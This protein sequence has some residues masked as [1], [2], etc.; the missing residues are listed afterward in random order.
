MGKSPHKGALKR[1]LVLPRVE[2]ECP[3]STTMSLKNASLWQMQEG[4][5]LLLIILY[6]SIKDCQ[7]TEIHL[8]LFVVPQKNSKR[9]DGNFFLVV[10]EVGNST[11]ELECVLFVGKVQFLVPRCIPQNISKLLSCQKRKCS[12]KKY[13]DTCFNLYF[14]ISN[15]IH[16]YCTLL[17]PTFPKRCHLFNITLASNKL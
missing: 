13:Q 14:K 4:G 5:K 12:K 8:I 3:S 9:L 2:T 16:E 7:K 11:S 15:P 6:S 17:I 1:E 10:C